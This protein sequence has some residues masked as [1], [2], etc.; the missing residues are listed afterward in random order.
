M[1]QSTHGPDRARTS[2]ASTGTNIRSSDHR[3]ITGHTA[4]SAAFTIN[5]AMPTHTALV[6]L[7]VKATNRIIRGNRNTSANTLRALRH[8][9]TFDTAPVTDR[10][11]GGTL[12]VPSPCIAWGP[13]PRSAVPQHTLLG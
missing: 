13:P 7:T 10:H 8:Y 3:G 12:I 6:A 1:H 9:M 11:S 2:L 5:L 4:F